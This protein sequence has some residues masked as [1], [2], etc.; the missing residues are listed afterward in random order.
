MIP[1]HI[2]HSKHN[3]VFPIKLKP[4]FFHGATHIGLEEILSPR[5]KNYKNLT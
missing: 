5:E 3:N 2:K 1:H 4:G